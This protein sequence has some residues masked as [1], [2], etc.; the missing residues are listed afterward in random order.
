MTSTDDLI[1]HARRCF[2]HA[3]DCTD[4]KSMRMFA[5]MALTYLRLAHETAAVVETGA[6]IDGAP[7]RA[8]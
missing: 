4:A 3:S 5:D 6:A 7:A 8:K 1:E 2:R